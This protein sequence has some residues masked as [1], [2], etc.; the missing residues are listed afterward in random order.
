MTDVIDIV[1]EGWRRGVRFTCR[2]CKQATV[3]AE[4]PHC[5]ECGQRHQ[6]YVEMGGPR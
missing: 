3:T 2:G 1:V 5:L 6:V 4:F